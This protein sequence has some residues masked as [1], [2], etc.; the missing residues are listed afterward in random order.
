VSV[1]VGSGIVEPRCTRTV[2]VF[3]CRA[4]GS[5]AGDE[6]D[7]VVAVST[8]RLPVGTPLPAAASAALLGRRLG[9]AA[10]D[11]VLRVVALPRLADGEAVVARFAAAAAAAGAAEARDL[12]RAMAELLYV[13]GVVDAEGAVLALGAAALALAGVD[14]KKG[15]PRSTAKLDLRTPSSSRPA[16]AAGT[17]PQQLLARPGGSPPPAPATPGGEI[18]PLPARAA[19]SPLPP[20]PPHL[21]LPAASE[22]DV[23]DEIMACLDRLRAAMDAAAGRGEGPTRAAESPPAADEPP[24]ADRVRF[25]DSLFTYE[26][27]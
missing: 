5:R 2:R 18:T 10:P 13:E 1:D 26:R 12:A 4:G 7:D 21:K 6:A 24:V 20:P 27:E 15:A 8:T 22:D 23:A 25:F 16:S 14:G 11:A 3:W 17:P 19:D 9:D